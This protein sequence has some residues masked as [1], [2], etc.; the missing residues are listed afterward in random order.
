MKKASVLLLALLMIVNVAQAAQWRDGTSPSQ[1][2]AGVP[3][4]NLS[5]EFG[6]LMFFPNMTIGAKNFCQKLLIYTPREDVRATDGEFHLCSEV[7]SRGSLWSTKM[8]D[9][10]AVTVRPIDEEELTGLLWGGGTCFEILLPDTLTLGQSYF[11]NMDEGCIVSTDGVK[12]PTIGGTDS[13]AFT[14]EGDYGVSAM[15]Y[16]RPQGKGYEEGILTPKKGDE[17]R[18]DLVLGGNASTAI[19][20]RN[21]ESVEFDET[22]LGRSGEVIGRVTGES[23][24]WGVM[25]LDALGNQVDRFEVGEAK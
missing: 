24:S 5:E 22:Y 13:W 11:V 8:N 17:I 10:E 18:F 3:Q 2:Y 9:T 19:V 15:Q 21:N 14:L 25:F 7:K 6:Y 23:P 4:V 1:P 20:Y 12:S 16:R